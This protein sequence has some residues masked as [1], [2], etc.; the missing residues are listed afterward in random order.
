MNATETLTKLSKEEILERLPL[1]LD[2]TEFLDLLSQ[3]SW[4]SKAY[5]SQFWSF[6]RKIKFEV[7]RNFFENM[8]IAIDTHRKRDVLHSINL[9]AEHTSKSSDEIVQILGIDMDALNTQIIRYWEQILDGLEKIH[10]DIIQLESDMARFYFDNKYY[11]IDS[12]CITPFLNDTEKTEYMMWY[13]KQRWLNKERKEPTKES[14]KIFIKRFYDIQNTF[15]EKIMSVIKEYNNDGNRIF[16]AIADRKIK[17]EIWDLSFS[18]HGIKE[19]SHLWWV[20]RWF[21]ERC[22][23]IRRELKK[24]KIS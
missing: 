23:Q 17:F 11:G 19:L 22:D 9:I 7:S 20:T 8:L 4:Y 10:Q 1:S 2:D 18:N 15:D 14:E 5:I 16:N 3:A 24:F 6:T 13:E 12:D 21:L